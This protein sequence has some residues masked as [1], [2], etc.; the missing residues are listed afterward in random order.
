MI[1]SVQ[2]NV[3]AMARDDGGQDQTPTGRRRCAVASEW[4]YC[5]CSTFSTERAEA[6]LLETKD[7]PQMQAT[8]K[9]RWPLRG[10]HVFMG[11]FVMICTGATIHYGRLWRDYQHYRSIAASFF[12]VPAKDIECKNP[13]RAQTNFKNAPEL[14][15]WGPKSQHVQYDGVSVTLRYGGCVTKFRRGKAPIN[16]S[17]SANPIAK[18]ILADKV[19]EFVREKWKVPD[20]LSVSCLQYEFSSGNRTG[21]A[22]FEVARKSA[23]MPPYLFHVGVDVFSGI[24]LTASARMWDYRQSQGSDG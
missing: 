21:Y 12:G 9:P 11:V 5:N 8:H 22:R 15:Q 4:G 18:E 16:A 17:N 20:V 19:S 7:S 14:T 1:P 24:V 13:W 3:N 2:A 23:N 6:A 10:S